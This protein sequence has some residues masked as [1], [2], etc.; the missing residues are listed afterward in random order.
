M[1]KR[2]RASDRVGPA[3]MPKR[4]VVPCVLRTALLAD[5][6]ALARAREDYARATPYPHACI[7]G[8]CEEEHLAAAKGEIVQHMKAHFKET[9]LFKVLQVPLDLACLE[10]SAPAV[11]A[12]MPHLL[13]LRDA[14]YAEPF[15]AMLR[16]L[17]GCGPLGPKSDMSVNI[18]APGH[19][20]LCHDDVIGT[21]RLSYIVYLTEPG[22]EWR[23]D[24]GG[25]LELYPMLPADGACAEQPS[26]TPSRFLLP[27]WNSMALF[28]VQPGRSFH[29]VGE[30]LGERP[31]MS[32]SGWF[33]R[34]DSEPV[35]AQ[36]ASLAQLKDVLSSTDA[37]T[38]N[39]PFE[40]LPLFTA[41][42]ADS[43]AP[44][45]EPSPL[46][47]LSAAERALLEA[48]L[49]PTY[50][51]PKSLAKIRTQF[52]AH[53]CMQLRGFLCDDVAARLD[54]LTRARD[55]ADGV[56]CT[57]HEQLA[58]TLCNR[59][60]LGVG[61]G[62]RAVGPPHMQ[63]FLRYEGE[64]GVQGVQPE[65][66]GAAPLA[67]EVDAGAALAQLG[68]TLA[69]SAAF[70]KY[71]LAL[72]Q[73][74]TVGC[75]ASVRR[76]RPGL[77][78]TVAHAAAMPPRHAAFLDATL[79]FVYEGP[80]PAAGARKKRRAALSVERAEWQS[81]EVGG[82]EAYLGAEEDEDP[83]V[84]AVYKTSAGK[85]GKADGG[86]GEG[87]QAGERAGEGIEAATAAEEEEEEGDLL[88]VE[89]SNNTLNLVMRDSGTLRFVKYLSAR[90]PGSRWDVAL[91]Y[92]VHPADLPGDEKDDDDDDDD[93]EEGEDDDDDDEEGEE[94]GDDE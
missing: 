11:A 88:N 90:A 25:A 22:R 84:T 60:E 70:Q 67:A 51:E 39:T 92:H 19:H 12:Q 52:A 30:V 13:A 76:F 79:C 94:G 80:A 6:A 82:F 57:P 64:Q 53:S 23:A 31:R 48:W 2:E 73:L 28:E 54:E 55:V 36:L 49:N 5:A 8:L 38:A 16:A 40:P 37:S 86:R 45:D 35:P 47:S 4:Q 89:A 85:A 3:A 50:L 56:G 34:P 26:T 17:T 87:L 24:E 58:G 7:R 20:L 74:R 43:A 61:G 69:R 78:Y 62:W 63:R 68:G 21:R 41:D 42:A 9:D 72:T 75:R 18:Y 1:G 15:R 33:H 32:I 10:Q 91:E 44:A 83:E 29:S 77:D 71:L 59:H 14:I 81:G 27:H 65:P 66:A 46:A 93:G